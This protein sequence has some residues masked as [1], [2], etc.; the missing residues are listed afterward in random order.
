VGASRRLD[1]HI[2]IV[3]QPDRHAINNALA[4]SVILVKQG[5]YPESISLESGKTLLVKGGHNSTYDQQTANTT[6]I[7]GLGQT[8][9]QA[10]SGS[11]KFEMLTIKPPQ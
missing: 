9:I 1:G 7:Q 11:L 8:T 2:S 6:F 5:T 3:R 10:P 4:G